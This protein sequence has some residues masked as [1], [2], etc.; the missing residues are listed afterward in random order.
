MNL[1][2]KDYKR[3]QV[4]VDEYIKMII[5]SKLNIYYDENNRKG[6]DGMKEKE[7]IKIFIVGDST[8]AAKSEKE[9]PMSGW[10]EYIGDCFVSNVLIE[11]YAVNGR[12]TKSFLKQGRL[13]RILSRI[14]SDDYVCI[15]FG[16]NDQKIEDPTRYTEPFIE[17]KD[18]LKYYIS[19]IRAKAA[20]PIL[21]TSISRR[22][23]TDR[24]ID[25]NSLGDYPKAMREVAE[26]EGVILIDM[27]QK[28]VEYLNELGEEKSKDLYLHLDPGE[29]E[30]YPTGLEDNTHFSEK[31]AKTIA[32][33][34]AEE[35]MKQIRK[36]DLKDN[37][38]FLR[39]SYNSL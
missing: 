29:Y 34:T 6:E 17:Y 33:L 37:I 24:R 10:G 36:S 20:H 1:I 13:D 3:F 32:Q 25:R 12:S 35:L 38:Q 27:H 26:E 21:I 30:N 31:G 11:N 8:A 4:K 18:N 19:Q 23:F 14:A 5:F 7:I 15:Q 22:Q 28:T 2:K 16:H 39:N 9:K